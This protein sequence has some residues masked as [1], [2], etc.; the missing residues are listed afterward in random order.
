MATKVQGKDVILYKIDTSVIPTSETPFACST[1]CTFNVQ[2]EQKE[3]SS[4][5]DAFFTEYLTDLSVWNASCEGIVTLS[6]FSY[7]QMAQVILDRTLF[8]IRFAIDNGDGGFKYISGYCFITNFDIS[9]SYKEIGTYGVTLQ[10]TGKYYTDATPTTTTSTT[11]TTT[12]TTSTTT[13]TTSTT[14]TSTTSTSTTTSTTTERA[15]LFVGFAASL[16]ATQ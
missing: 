11:S 12:S 7:Q 10:G 15:L 6:G 4:R 2:V 9:G 16:T 3:V 5:T 13:S 1:N 14:T 8:L